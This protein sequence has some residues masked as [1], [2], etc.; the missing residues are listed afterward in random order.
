MPAPLIT[1]LV[2]AYNQPEAL[3]EL[4]ASLSRQTLQDFEVIVVNDAGCPL[5]EVVAAYPE[6]SLTLVERTTNIGQTACLNQA[7][8]LARGAYVLLLDH[9]DMLWERHLETVVA[10]I[11][12]AD[13]VFTDAELYR[14]RSEAGRRVPVSRRVLAHRLDPAMLRRYL[15]FTPSGMLYRRSLHEALGGFDVALRG[16]HYDWD[17]ALRVAEAHRLVR[18]PVAS[19][20][21]AFG[22]HNGSSHPATMQPALD[23]LR[24][25]H[26]LGDVIVT[27]FERMLDDP[28]LAPV[29]ATSERVWDG[30]PRTGR[31]ASASVTAP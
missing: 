9:D 2:T 17:W 11:A 5:V 22:E 4:L 24:A 23:H 25:K 14:Y 31:W 26:G 27:N 28:E 18:V 30:L 8:A 7:A 10:A 13:L 15:T 21:Y 19:V 16:S 3:D 29:R 20:Y 6:L 12:E 1:V